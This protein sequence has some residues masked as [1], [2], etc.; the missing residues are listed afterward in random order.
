M[1]SYVSLPNNAIY[2]VPL[3][4]LINLSVLLNLKKYKKKYKKVTHE[5]KK[6]SNLGK[7]YLLPKIHKR[8]YKISGRPA[9][10]NYGTPTEKA[11]EFLNYY[12]KLI[13]QRGKFYMKDS[14]DFIKKFGNLQNVPEDGILVMEDIV[15]PYP[16]IPH[17]VGLN[18]LRKP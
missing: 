1:K 5:Y 8:L 9:T 11:S 10:S 14:S 7:L 15:G 12:I 4:T 18:V 13:M 17:E 2:L 3:K 16:S 6:V